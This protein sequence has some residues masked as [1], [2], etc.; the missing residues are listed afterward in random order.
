MTFIELLR[1][2][3]TNLIKYKLRPVKVA[4]LDT[5]IDASHCKLRGKIKQAYGY[6]MQD[7]GEIKQVQ[8][9]KSSN[10]DPSGHGTGVASI[11][12]SLAPNTTFIDYRV[13]S[14]DNAGSG[15]IV[16]KALEH[17]ISSD[18]DIINISITL[19]KGKYWD[20]TVVL[21]EKAYQ[22][23][24][25]VVASKRNIPMP[26][27]L[28]LPAELSSCISV[29]CAKFSTPYFIKFLKQST[30]E[31]A[32]NGV[33]VLTAKTG[34]GYHRLTGT[35]FA[36]PTVAAL[37]A[38]MR[39]LLPD[40]HLFEI[41]TVLKNHSILRKKSKK[42]FNPLEMNTQQNNVDDFM[43]KHKCPSCE[44]EMTIPDV[45]SFIRCDK[46]NHISKRKPLLD[47]YLYNAGLLT[48]RNTIPDSLCYHNHNHARR[49]V[50]AIFYLIAD[51]KTLSLRQKRCLLLA[52]VLHD[53]GYAK[54][55]ENHEVAGA[56]LAEILLRDFNVPENDICLIKKLILATAPSHSPVDYAEK[57][58]KDADLYYVG[59]KEGLKYSEDLRKEYETQDIFFSDEEW[60][61]REINFLSTHKF[62]LKKLEK[63]RSAERLSCL[64][65]YAKMLDVKN[66]SEPKGIDKTQISEGILTNELDVTPE[67]YCT[68]PN[69][70]TRFYTNRLTPWVRCPNSKCRMLLPLWGDKF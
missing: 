39:G 69:C 51:C 2:D 10:N 7:N 13:L 43:V 24:K 27:D 70:K 53:M 37:V 62:Y 40:L 26:N 6:S 61:V 57:V 20:A 33:G 29:D 14:P 46:C 17:A 1:I 15:S 11:I 56:E 21:L 58:I 23:N 32:A 65:H 16:L 8:L 36:T 64:E 3:L 28:G 66:I 9:N 47:V 59:T 5:G 19:P 4:I 41:K 42:K 18:V 44:S 25:I 48:I 12:S 30:I 49:T 22:C 31:Y 52:G 35:S 54:T 68:C 34:G 50:Q 67:S 63:L 60:I 38:L 55:I 45:F